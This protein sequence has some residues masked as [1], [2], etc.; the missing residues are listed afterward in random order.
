MELLVALEPEAGADAEETDRL[1]RQLSRELRSL[2]VDVAPVVSGAAPPGAKGVDA[3][4]L[5]QLL[6]TLS[7][8]G[9]VFATVIAT[10]RDWLGRHSGGHKVT[11]TIDGDSL[12]LDGAT[13]AERAELIDTFVRRHQPV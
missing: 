5:T 1:S 13:A 11:V 12:E 6:V 4:S 7:G 3:A 10:V 2:D 9:G 8:T